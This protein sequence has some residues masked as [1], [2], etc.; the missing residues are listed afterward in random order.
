MRRARRKSRSV[1]STGDRRPRRQQALVERDA[2]ARRHLE[3]EVVDRRGAGR[4]IRVQAG[5]ERRRRGPGVRRV[6]RRHEAAGAEPVVDGDP[7]RERVARLGLHL[8]DEG[9]VAGRGADR[10]PPAPG[11]EAVQG[12]AALGLRQRGPV[13][14]PGE[15]VAPVAQP[16]RPGHEHL[17][18]EGVVG[19]ARAGGVEQ[20]VPA[21]RSRS[22]ARRRPWSRPRAAAGPRAPARS[23]PARPSPRSSPYTCANSRPA[24]PQNTRHASAWRPGLRTW[25][26]GPP[27]RSHASMHPRTPESGRKKP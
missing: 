2:R 12:G 11:R 15:D 7:Q 26:C 8:V 13:L 3:D 17:P 18:A 19:L 4:E 6:E 1:P 25:W 27:S 24:M 14:G 22:A 16:V 20:L 9:E 23:S 10:P 5:A 21:R